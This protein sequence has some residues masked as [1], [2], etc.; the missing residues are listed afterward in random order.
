MDASSTF[1]KVVTQDRVFCKMA[2]CNLK[3]VR[4]INCAVEWSVLIAFL[5]LSQ[6]LFTVATTMNFMQPFIS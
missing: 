1:P 3:L 5:S 4:M 2:S 6:I